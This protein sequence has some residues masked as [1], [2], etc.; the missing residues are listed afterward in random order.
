MS[1]PQ[2][3]EAPTTA[4]E[5]RLGPSRRQP[6]RV[7]LVDDHP[8]VR[9]G[10]TGVIA[11]YPEL[12]TIATAPTARDALMQARHHHPE[13]VVVDY[14]LPDQDGLALAH[15][16]KTLQPPP[17]VLV[18]SAFADPP[19]AIGA[20]VAGADGV[21]SKGTASDELRYA[22]RL[23]ADG[24]RWMPKITPATLSWMAA[25]LDP[26]DAPILRMLV[27][28]AAPSE[29]AEALGIGEEWLDAR[30]WAMLQQL[31]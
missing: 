12:S 15:R 11:A 10:L 6:V 7:L 31:R 24:G 25:R 27:H 18:Y 22:I 21:A 16:L 8:A 9:D 19:M 26:E 20:I 5:L 30:R 4:Y 2:P 1:A 29:I 13:V 3:R 23:I 17:A 28:G 14:Y